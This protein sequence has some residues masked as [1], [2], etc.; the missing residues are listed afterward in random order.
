FVIALLG[1][2]LVLEITRR[3]SGLALPILS[4]IFILYSFLGPYIPGILGHNGYNFERFFSYICSLNVIFGVTIDV[5]ARYI[6][7]FITFGAFLEASRVGKY[8]MDLSFSVAG[9]YRGGPAKVAVVS[10]GLMGMMS[11]AAAAN[12]AT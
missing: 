6:I 2:V 9:R 1:T 8:F 5:S 11:G 3:T 4:M 10:S 12:V 7:L